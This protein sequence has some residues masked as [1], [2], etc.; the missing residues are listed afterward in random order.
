LADTFST[1]SQERMQG[2]I[3]NLVKQFPYGVPTMCYY[4]CLWIRYQR[5]PPC[6]L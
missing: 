3:P 6:A 4:V 1:S 2:S 5:W